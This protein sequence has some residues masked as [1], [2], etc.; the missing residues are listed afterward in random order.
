ME[1]LSLFLNSPESNPRHCRMS[2]RRR[3]KALLNYPQNSA[4]HNCHSGSSYSRSTLTR[5]PIVNIKFLFLPVISDTAAEPGT[6]GAV[7]V[8]LPTVK[9]WKTLTHTHH[10]ELSFTVRALNVAIKT[11]VE[12]ALVS[13]EQNVTQSNNNRSSC[14]TYRAGHAQYHLECTNVNQWIPPFL[15]NLVKRRIHIE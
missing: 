2:S 1:T 14:G 15:F 8:L 13:L 5:L 11:P 12:V 7:V 9:N 3:K 6:E 10:C 4:S